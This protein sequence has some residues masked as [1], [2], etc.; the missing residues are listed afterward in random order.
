MF[1]RISGLKSVDGWQEIEPFLNH[2]E[3]LHC[4][5]QILGLHYIHQ[6]IHLPF[7]EVLY[8]YCLLYCTTV[9]YA[10]SYCICTVLHFIASHIALQCIAHRKYCILHLGLDCITNRAPSRAPLNPALTSALAP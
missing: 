1:M 2:L 4:T 5:L 9:C 10:A 7:C 3:P 6:A 8:V